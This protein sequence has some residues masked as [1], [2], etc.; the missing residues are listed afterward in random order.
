MLTQVLLKFLYF[1]RTCRIKL[2]RKTKEKKQFN[3]RLELQIA[4][5]Y[6]L[7]I[8]IEICISWLNLMMVDDL[9][10]NWAVG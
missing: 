2:L 9:R 8:G 7:A 6:F 10:E 4:C 3:T 1:R 5:M